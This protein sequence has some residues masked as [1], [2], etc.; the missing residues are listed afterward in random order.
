MKSPFKKLNLYKKINKINNKI[1]IIG[2]KD[3]LTVYQLYV[4]YLEKKKK[5]AN[6]W[7]SIKR[8]LHNLYKKSEIKKLNVKQ[9]YLHKNNQKEYLF[10]IWTKLQYI[11]ALTNQKN[12]I[13]KY[14]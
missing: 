7:M 14:K 5:Q 6:K 9:S 10:Q 1:K 4:K 13:F 2:L 12:M 11:Q 8:N 3:I